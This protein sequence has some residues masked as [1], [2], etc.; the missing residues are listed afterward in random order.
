MYSQSQNGNLSQLDPSDLDARYSVTWQPV[1]TTSLW[2]TFTVARQ[3]GNLS[4]LDRQNWTL[5]VYWQPFRTRSL[6]YTCIVSR[7]NGNLSQ[8]DPSDLDA[9][10]S[11]YWQPFRT[12]S[13]WYRFTVASQNGNLSGLD[14]QNWTLA[15][16]WQPIRTRS[17]IVSRQNGNLSQTDPSDLDAR[18]SLYWQ[19]VRP[20]SLWILQSLAEIATCQD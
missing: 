6:E 7:L 14:R 5:A 19:P 4:G 8:T 20:T 12:T 13:L 15:V 3:N 1:S 10:Y 17:C 9:R 11:L 18:Y 2:Y 16:N